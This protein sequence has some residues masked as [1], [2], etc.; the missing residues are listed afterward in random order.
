MRSGDRHDALTSMSN[1]IRPDSELPGVW[2]APSVGRRLERGTALT[3]PMWQRRRICDGATSLPARHPLQSWARQPV[4][5]PILHRHRAHPLVERHGRRVPVED[6][7]FQAAA[8]ALERQRREALQQETADA[9]ATRL[10]NHEQV[11]QVDAPLREEGREVFEEQREPDRL[12]VVFRNQHL[13][14]RPGPE[15][16]VAQHL[17]GGFHRI[18][19]LLVVGQAADE[20][21]NQRHVVHGSLTDGDAGGRGRIGG[22]IRGGHIPL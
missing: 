7:P 3:L 4:H 1:V 18:Q 14:G 19:Q 13:G 6:G 20:R 8:S 10:G 9:A 16:R 21:K 12:A 15:E 22:R 5:R 17:L 2:S 11:F